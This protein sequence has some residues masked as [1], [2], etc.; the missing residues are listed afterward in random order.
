MRLVRYRERWAVVIS[1]RRFSTGV[2]IG[3]DRAI[4]ERKARAI[5][6]AFA[7]ATAGKR[8]GEI[9]NAYVADMPLRANPKKPGAGLLYAKKAVTAFFGGHTPEEVTREECRAYVAHRRAEGRSDGTIRKELGVLAA[10]LRWRDPHTPARFDMPAPPPARDRWLTKDEFNAVLGAVELPH[11]KTFLHVAICT[12]ARKEAILTMQ[13]D[14]HVN[15]ER[16]TLWPGFKAGGKGRAMPIPMTEDAREWL[17]KAKEDALSP[18]LVEWAG[19]KVG[20]LKRALRTAYA[21]AGVENVGA[22]AHVL[23]HTAGAW[24][25][26][27]GVPM[28]EISRRLGH[29]SVSVTE[30]HYAH[31]HPDYMGASTKALELGK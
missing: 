26:L 20:D 9:M 5:V 15:F 7:K 13:W 14:T 27:A 17:L 29:S 19:E 11:V 12:G 23:R 16:G 22:P 1:G 4:A 31:L 21:R 6:E 18:W 3:G 24:M 8:C 28:L 25:A 2:E 30:R 10:A